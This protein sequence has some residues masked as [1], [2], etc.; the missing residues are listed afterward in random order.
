[1]N[2]HCEEHSDEAIPNTQVEIASLRSQWH[3]LFPPPPAACAN[4]P[5]LA[6]QPEFGYAQ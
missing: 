5:H 6:A 2:R 1:M 4:L 3:E